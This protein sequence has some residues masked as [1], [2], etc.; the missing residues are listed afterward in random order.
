MEHTKWKFY[1]KKMLF[2]I[3]SIMNITCVSG[4]HLP[5][6]PKHRPNGSYCTV[7][8]FSNDSLLYDDGNGYLV[9]KKFFFRDFEEE[10]CAA[11]ANFCVSMQEQCNWMRV[12][13]SGKEIIR[14]TVRC[15]FASELNFITFSKVP[16]SSDIVDDLCVSACKELYFTVEGDSV[17][18]ILWDNMPSVY[19]YS[20]KMK[21]H[22]AYLDRFLGTTNRCGLFQLNIPVDRDSYYCFYMTDD[23]VVWL[24]FL[25]DATIHTIPQKPNKF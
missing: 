5:K 7:K 9:G 10:K 24:H 17:A 19:V 11:F 6:P 18:T 8:H 22:R 1:I 3:L 2:I 4:Q 15:Q 25:G 13:E 21:G 12:C 16:D 14:L 20:L 23:F